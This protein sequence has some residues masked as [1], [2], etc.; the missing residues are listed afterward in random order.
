MARKDDDD[1]SR[2]GA[3]TS[4]TLWWGAGGLILLVLIGLVWVL[5]NA[6]KSSPAAVATRT[7]TAPATTP[8]GAGAP[9]T[10]PASSA[11]T[12]GN[13]SGCNVPGGNA[14]VPTAAIPA[15]W[16]LVGSVAAPVSPTAGPTKITGTVRSCYQDSPSG[17]VLA[18]INIAVALNSSSEQE[19]ISQQYTQGPGRSEAAALPAD[20]GNGSISGFQAQACTQSACLVKV[21]VSVQGSYV[22]Q[23]MP[24]IWSGGD[25]KVNGQV[26][27]VAQP[28]EVSSLSPYVVMNAQGAS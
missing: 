25:W 20:S 11:T 10:T 9:P 13:A 7:V 5:I 19:V 23:T 21:A 12:T 3:M 27:G 4:S 8:S 17:A 1:G 2:T 26:T 22:E 16:Q 6:G 15:T 18:A 24:M 28:V 14:L